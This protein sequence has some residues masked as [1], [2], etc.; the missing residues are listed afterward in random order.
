[1]HLKKLYLDMFDMSPLSN[2]LGRV[3][4]LYFGSK[5]NRSCFRAAKYTC[6]RLLMNLS[7]IDRLSCCTKFQ[8]KGRL[9]FFLTKTPSS[10][11]HTAH[12]SQSHDAMGL[13]GGWGGRAEVYWAEMW[14]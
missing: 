8:P 10:R 7:G 12:A 11:R 5:P 1:M 2:I 4:A 14:Q 9:D 6:M 13:D 3:L